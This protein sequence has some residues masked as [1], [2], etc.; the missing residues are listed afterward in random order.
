ML[1]AD[2]GGLL[3]G[4]IVVDAEYR[5]IQRRVEDQAPDLRAE[6]ARPG[7]AEDGVRREAVDSGQVHTRTE[8]PSTLDLRHSIGNV[9]GVLNRVSKSK[10][11]VVYF[12]K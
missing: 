6:E 11:L 10:A 9:I 4:L 2:I 1:V 7:M 3:Q 8:T 5:C 12:Q